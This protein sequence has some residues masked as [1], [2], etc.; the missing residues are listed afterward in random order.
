MQLL[1]D[2]SVDC[3]YMRCWGFLVTALFFIAA[4]GNVAMMFLFQQSETWF[5]SG[6]QTIHLMLQNCHLNI[7]A[8]DP[9]DDLNASYPIKAYGYR[10]TDFVV[11]D[12]DMNTF[13]PST[14][15]LFDSPLLH[16]YKPDYASPSI[17]C[18]V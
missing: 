6:N 12:Y 14:P 4:M 1:F 3:S 7:T 18:V 17:D 16:F 5:F 8:C 13:A 2:S 15:S 10:G 9:C 11:F